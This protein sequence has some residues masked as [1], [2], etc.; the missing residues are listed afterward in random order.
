V[1]R[2][3]QKRNAEIEALM[4]KKLERWESLESK[5]KDGIS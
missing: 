5:H 2:G 3:D 4:M 1:L